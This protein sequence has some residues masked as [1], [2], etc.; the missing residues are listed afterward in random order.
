MR[1]KR[2]KDTDYLFISTRLRT[3]ERNF[4]T[5]AR[6]DRMIDAPTAEDAAKVLAEIGYGDFSLSSE[7]SLNQVLTAEREKVLGDLTP[8]VPDRKVV[9]VFR[10]KYDYHNAK[11]MLKALAVGAE[12]ARL[13]VDAG[14]MPAGALAEAV[15]EGAYDKLP[16]RLQEAVREAAEV[17]SATGDPQRS[18]FALD[19]AYYQEMLELAEDTGSTFLTDYVR[20]TIDSANL[21]SAVRTLRMKKGGDFLRK[22]LFP[23]GTVPEEQV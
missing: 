21:R 15:R 10:V 18:D 22:V 9:D 3:L 1:R 13:L 23:G 14:R 20:A 19:R 4:L 2:I 11:T 6:M 5:A 7:Q 8:L 17:L 12:P 16:G